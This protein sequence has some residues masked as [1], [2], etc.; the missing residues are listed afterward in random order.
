MHESPPT[1]KHRVVIAGGGIAA[2]ETLLALR[3]LVPTRLDVVVVAPN[4]DLHYRPLTVNEPFSEPRAR[5]YRLQTICDDLGAVLHADAV[6]AVDRERRELV[7]MSRERIAYDALVLAVGARPDLAIAHA[8]TFL[9]DLNA[10]KLHGFVRDVEDGYVRGLALVVPPKAGWALPLYELAL[11]T[12]ARARSMGAKGLKLTIVTNEDVPLAAFRGA[13]SDAVA[14]LLEEAG[15]ATVCSTYVTEFDGRTL[16]LAPGSRS[17]EVDAVLALPELHGPALA[18]VPCDPDG[19][20]HADEHGRVPD[21]DDVYAIGDATTFPI[22]Q[23]GIAAQQAD[24]VAALIAR[25]AGVEARAPRTRPVLRAILLTGAEPLYLS[26][27]ITGGESVSSQ[28]STHCMWWP[29]HKVAARHLAPYLADREEAGPASARRHAL[30]ARLDD[31][32]I[33]AHADGEVGFELLGRDA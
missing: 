14:T 1:P 30:E 5:R 16:A 11:M 26:A 25:S 8:H 28:V 10:D 15:I 22:K 3:S 12:A 17:L 7:T 9:A 6:Q 27:T 23:G 2:V 19:F 13:G 4:E 33:V 21:L 31:D 29:P 32:P 18:G 24:V 20:I